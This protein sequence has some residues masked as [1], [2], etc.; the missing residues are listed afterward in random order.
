MP[1]SLLLKTTPMKME[2]SIITMKRGI[3]KSNT[4]NIRQTII[5]IILMFMLITIIIV[6]KDSLMNIAFNI[7]VPI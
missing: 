6:E 4:L 5:F 7:T 3:A 2:L 1:A